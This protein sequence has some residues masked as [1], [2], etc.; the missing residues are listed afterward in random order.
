MSKFLLYFYRIIL[1]DVEFVIHR[2]FFPFSTFE[3][4][5]LLASMVSDKKWATNLTEDSSYTMNAFSC[6]FQDFLLDCLLVAWL[7]CVSLW[8]SLSSSSLKFIGLFGRVE[9]C[10]S[11][12]ENILQVFFLPLSLFSFGDAYM[13]ICWYIWWCPTRLCSSFIFL[14]SSFLFLRPKVSIDLSPR[15][16]LPAQICFWARRV[17]YFRYYSFELHNFY[18]FPFYNFCFFLVFSI[19]WDIILTVPLALWTYFK[20]QIKSLYPVSLTSGLPQG[21][22]LVI[23]FFS[24]GTSRIFSCMPYNFVVVV[25][26]RAFWML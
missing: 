25:E 26:N 23:D 3:Y 2:R 16:L 19:R 4:V 12:D 14:H 9:W 10:F 7:Y 17:I 5:I 6:C 13:Y 15:T 21:Q 11:F 20:W 22:L 1:P 8:L 24:L 18:L